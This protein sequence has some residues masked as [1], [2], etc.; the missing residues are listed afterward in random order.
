MISDQEFETLYQKI[1]GSRLSEKFDNAAP[2]ALLTG[3][4]IVIEMIVKKA[5]LDSGIDMDWHYAAG[6][7]IVYSLGDADQ[8]RRALHDSMPTLA[9]NYEKS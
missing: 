5:S 2:V 3:P 9:L 4:A 1:R 8:S 6:R 7:G